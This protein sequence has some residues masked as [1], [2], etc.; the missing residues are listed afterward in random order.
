[1]V[2]AFPLM[3]MS[4]GGS[5]ATTMPSKASPA[6]AVMAV[7]L[8][9]V[10]MTPRRNVEHIDLSKES[11]PVWSDLRSFVEDPKSAPENSQSCLLERTICRSLNF[12]ID[13][14]RVVHRCQEPPLPLGVPVVPEVYMITAIS[15]GVGLHNSFSDLVQHYGWK[16]SWSVARGA[17]MKIWCTCLGHLLHLACAFQ[18]YSILIPSRCAKETFNGQVTSL[19]FQCT[20]KS[21]TSPPFRI[22]V[23]AARWDFS[24]F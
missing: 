21:V 1:M 8:A 20:P 23:S 7:R 10:S 11:I 6:P 4:P 13:T 22:P 3:S 24:V 16:I 9:C 14:I 15:S 17:Y 18:T 5:P 2:P 19:Q 12:D